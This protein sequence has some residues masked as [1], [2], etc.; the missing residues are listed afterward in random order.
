M[1]MMTMMYG[2][3]S[4]AISWDPVRLSHVVRLIAWS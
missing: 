4:S 1:M 2:L 3:D